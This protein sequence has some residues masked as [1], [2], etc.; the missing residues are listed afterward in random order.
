MTRLWYTPTPADFVIGLGASAAM[1]DA[2]EQP[3]DPPREGRAALVPTT[4]DTF[5]V[6]V[7]RELNT[8]TTDLLDSSDQP[9]ASWSSSTDFETLGRGP[10]FQGPDGHEGPLYLS[11]PGSTVGYRVEPDSDLLYAR[12]GVLWDMPPGRT[13]DLE[14]VSSESPT[15]GDVPTWDESQGQYRPGKPFLPVSGAVSFVVVESTAPHTEAR[16]DAGM[17]I[18]IG[19]T[20]EPQNTVAGTDLWLEAV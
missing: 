2:A 3:L 17:V 19:G 7:D 16:P 10:S 6:F 4:S 1:L 12:V 15:S 14:D 8:Q 9:L 11:A 13:S 20:E 5:D 18:W